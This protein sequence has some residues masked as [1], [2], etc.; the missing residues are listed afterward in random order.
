MLNPA[1]LDGNGPEQRF[2]KKL[3]LNNYYQSPEVGTREA[4]FAL[5]PKATEHHYAEW[6]SGIEQSETDPRLPMYAPANL[7]ETAL[8]HPNLRGDDGLTKEQYGSIKFALAH[9]QTMIDV[10]TA[11]SRYDRHHGFDPS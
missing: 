10:F 7:C 9:Y 1:S 3:S 11:I 5:H 2:R 8:D 4:F 6:K